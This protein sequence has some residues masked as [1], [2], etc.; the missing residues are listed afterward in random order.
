LGG[1]GRWISKFEASLG[2]TEKCCL[3]PIPSSS[4]PIPNPTPCIPPPEKKVESVYIGSSR[5]AMVTQ[6]KTKQNK[7]KRKWGAREIDK[8]LR[9][10]VLTKDPDSVLS[11]HRAPPNNP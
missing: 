2:Y 4:L 8:R 9:T 7:S 11:T 3:E 10:F 1:R 5:L 6:N